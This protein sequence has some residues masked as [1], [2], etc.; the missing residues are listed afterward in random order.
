MA[1]NTY[2]STLVAI[3]AGLL[4]L[5]SC[6]NGN[7]SYI[8]IFAVKKI[9]Q[10]A[11]QLFDLKITVKDGKSKDAKKRAEFDFISLV[12]ERNGKETDLSLRQWGDRGEDS[13]FGIGN[14]YE[15]VKS[16]G[17]ATRQ[18]NDLYYLQTFSGTLIASVSGIVYSGSNKNSIPIEITASKG[19]KGVFTLN[20]A[21][22]KLTL[23]LSNAEAAQQYT[24][25]LAGNINYLDYGVAKIVTTDADGK[26]SSTWTL[27]NKTDKRKVCEIEFAAKVTN[28]NNTRIISTV[29]EF[30]CLREYDS[31]DII[32]NSEGS[33]FFGDSTDQHNCRLDHHKEGEVR[34]SY[35]EYDKYPVGKTEQKAK[36][37]MGKAKNKLGNI[38][39]FKPDELCY[40]I[41]VKGKF[42]CSDREGSG[43][44]GIIDSRA[45]HG[46]CATTT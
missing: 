26:V 4:C 36:L 15:A 37:D 34:W 17:G 13:S 10:E 30:P 8:P 42:E 29:I 24:I 25:D 20:D 35:A 39:D 18:Y 38:A 44:R 11:G 21:T 43:I 28:N 14:K 40:Y 1:V 46:K 3:C 12:L 16:D 2:F 27:T 31:G 19:V 9:K 7:S 41:V 22:D 33:V 23:Q 32:V 45:I 6:S 5:Q